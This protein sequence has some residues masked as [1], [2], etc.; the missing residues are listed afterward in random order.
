MS[1]PN[2]H[3]AQLTAILLT[4]DEESNITL[5]LGGLEWI[6]DI[7]ILDSGSVDLTVP[8]ARAARP[9]V[10]IFTREFDDFGAQ[11]QW[12]LDNTGPK[13][14]WILFLD[15]DESIPDACR[16]EI[17]RVIRVDEGPSGYYMT[18]VNH[19]LGKPIPRSSL[20]PSWQLR[21]LKSGEVSFHKEGHGQRELS[22]GRLAY[23]A[24]PYHHFPFSK[25]VHQWIHRHNVYSDEE[26]ELWLKLRRDKLS[27]SDLVKGPVPRR[28][29]IKRI[30]ARISARPIIS[31][32]NSY[33]L[34]M[35]F[36]EGRSGLAF[37]LLR[38]S[39]DLQ[40][41]VKISEAM[42][43]LSDRPRDPGERF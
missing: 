2:N 19:F 15:A 36:L 1:G 4:R 35:G 12:A 13:H 20:Y 16:D 32:L 34:R 43:G 42:S 41:S 30:V 17:L 11:R 6:D 26:V 29:C 23:I 21:L 38:L 22:K 18:G 24:A 25:G 9:D 7:I 14:E 3:R 8:K 28:R 40:I 5:C 27:L 39:Y 31:F 33:I 10:R 37:C